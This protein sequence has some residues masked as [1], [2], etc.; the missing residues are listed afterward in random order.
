MLKKIFKR[1]D[2]VPPTTKSDSQQNVSVITAVFTGFLVA[3]IAVF[4]IYTYVPKPAFI[5]RFLVWWYFNRHS[6][7]PLPPPPP[8]PP[9]PL[10]PTEGQEQNPTTSLPT[11]N[12]D[13]HDNDGTQDLPINDNNNNNNAIELTDFNTSTALPNTTQN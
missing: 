1:Q 12:N 13:N 9:S 5:D 8:P 3:F 4:M 7:P 11:Q 2:M 6:P 10:P